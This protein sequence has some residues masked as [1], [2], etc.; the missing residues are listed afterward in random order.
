[1]KTK[2]MYIELK[3]HNGGHDDNGPACITL[4]KFSKTGKSIYF[5]DKILQKYNAGCGNY[6]DTDSEDVYWVS[7]PKKN[8]QDRYQWAGEK[9][10]IDDD[11][12]EEYWIDIRNQPENIN[13][14]FV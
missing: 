5:R 13:K 11:V 10:K 4:V 8:G 14:E 3:T 2:I 1:M 12:R 6:I 7:G 9:T